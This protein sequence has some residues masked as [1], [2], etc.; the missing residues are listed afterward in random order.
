MDE[1]YFGGREGNK[2][3]HK[4]Q[5]LGRGGVGK[6]VVVGAKDRATN[7]VRAEVV[8]GTDAETLQGFVADHA[9]PG[10]TVYTDEAAAYKGMPF[11]HE[12]VRHSTGEYVKEMAHTNGMESFWSMLKRAHKGTLATRP[13]LESWLMLTSA[14]RRPITSARFNPNM[15]VSPINPGL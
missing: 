8:E 6:A 7:E 10:A 4:K 14:P 13:P 3:S 11:K 12:S 2:H 15:I 1:T 9:T 5:R